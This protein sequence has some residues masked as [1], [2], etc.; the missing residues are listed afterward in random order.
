MP[1]MFNNNPAVFD[2]TKMR[3]ICSEDSTPEENS[4]LHARIGFHGVVTVRGQQRKSEE[5]GKQ[6]AAPKLKDTSFCGGHLV[7]TSK[8]ATAKY[9]TYKLTIPKFTEKSTVL[10]FLVEAECV[11]ALE[12]LKEEARYGMMGPP[13]FLTPEN[14]NISPDPDLVDAPDKSEE[15]EEDE[16]S[17]WNHTGRKDEDEDDG[18]STKS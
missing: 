14:K 12:I 8:V 5:L 2:N 3:H 13:D 15:E 1:S 18:D 17:A 16:D 6:G 7:R 4:E 11:I 10:L 9:V